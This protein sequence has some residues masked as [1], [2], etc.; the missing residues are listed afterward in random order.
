MKLVLAVIAVTMMSGCASYQRNWQTGCLW[1]CA[2][3]DEWR[4]QGQLANT[5]AIANTYTPSK[6]TTAQ[7]YITPQGGFQVIRSGSTTT[8]IQTSKSK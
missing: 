8:V 7:T 3:W 4:E 1:D 5:G 6:G 2:K